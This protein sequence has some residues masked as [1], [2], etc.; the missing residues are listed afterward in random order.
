MA[1][2]TGKHTINVGNLESHSI[3]VD[4]FL[5]EKPFEVDDFILNAGTG[6]VVGSAFILLGFILVVLSFV[7]LALKR[8]LLKKTKVS[9]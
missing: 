9:K 2:T 6:V 4:G 1:N 5:T 3:K 8:F 7:I